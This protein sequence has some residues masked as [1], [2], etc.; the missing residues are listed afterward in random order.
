MQKNCFIKKVVYLSIL[1]NGAYLIFLNINLIAA[2]SIIESKYSCT[3]EIPQ[4][5]GV[6]EKKSG[7]NTSESGEVLLIALKNKKGPD[8]FQ[9]NLLVRRHKLEKSTNLES[10]SRR[11]ISD[12]SISVPNY[13]LIDSGKIVIKSDSVKWCLSKLEGKF[14]CVATKQFFIVDKLTGFLIAFATSCDSIMFYEPVFDST[15]RSFKFR[16]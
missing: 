2:G 6:F 10:F 4:D 12:D 11:I 9:E 8:S 1:I 16:N 7:L 5:W 3:I 15:A 14:G 13:E